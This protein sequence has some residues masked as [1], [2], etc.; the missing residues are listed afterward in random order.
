MSEL[1]TR[2]RLIITGLATAA[3]VPGLVVARASPISTA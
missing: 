3:G 2:R 1:I